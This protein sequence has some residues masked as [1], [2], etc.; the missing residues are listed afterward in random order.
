MTAPAALTLTAVD[1]ADVR[2][3]DAAGR[4]RGFEATSRCWGIVDQHGRALTFD[5]QHPAT[6]DRKRTAQ[7]IAD[8][9][10]TDHPTHPAQW[11]TVQH[12]REDT[13]AMTP[14]SYAEMRRQRAAARRAK[15]ARDAREIQ[16]D[17]DLVAWL[18]GS[19]GN[20]PEADR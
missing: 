5:G 6:W 17:P 13:A 10:D 15:R 20:T 16:S 14:T 1:L 3:Q 19:D 8:T 7:F 12:P 11:V 18:T 4:T 9:I 2:W